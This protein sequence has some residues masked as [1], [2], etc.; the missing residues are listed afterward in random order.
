VAVEVTTDEQ[1]DEEI[2]LSRAW[3]WALVA[4]GIVGAIIFYLLTMPKTVPASELPAH[5]PDL[6][7]GKYMFIAGGCAECHA[8]PLTRCRDTKTRDKLQLS[9]GRCLKTEFGVFNV[10][11]ISPD[12]ETGIGKWTTLDFVNAM[13]RGIGPE[14]AHLYP[15]FPYTSYQRMTYEDLIDL[16]AY[17]DTLP[18]VKNEVAP[19]ALTFPYNIRRAVGLWQLLYVDGKTFTP[20]AKKS[21]EL[22]RGAYLV[23][24]PG[25]CGECHTPR[26]FIGGTMQNES[27]AGARNPEG[28]GKIPNITPSHDGIGSWSEEEIVDFLETGNTPDFDVVGGLMAPVQENIA[29]LTPEDRAAI[30]EFLKSLPPRKDA[31]P[32][33]KSGKDEEEGEEEGDTAGSAPNAGSKSGGSEE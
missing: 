7:N 25:H 31:V 18:P 29:K 4:L 30:A 19:H 13:K 1:D 33:R 3:W 6:A 26:N 22:N 5:E 23:E 9:G 10:P 15:A 16:K 17:L 27:F 14:G 11:N 20:D 24:G 28:K 12:K 32:K 21:E 8:K 2:K